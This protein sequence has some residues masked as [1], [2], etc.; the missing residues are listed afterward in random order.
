MPDT[1]PNPP[2]RKMLLIDDDPKLLLGLKA[3]MT[4]QGFEVFSTIDGN[5]GI[6]MAREQ[7]PDIIICDVMMPKPDGFSIKR[8]LAGNPQTA[9][10]P[11]IYL[12]ARTFTADKIAGLQLGADDYV[13]KPFNA[14]ELVSRVEAI[15][16]RGNIGHQRGLREMED[17]LEQMR[18]SISTN[19]AHE[20]RT[21]L[22][23]IMAN[24]TMAMKEKFHGRADDMNWY[25]E[26]MLSSTQKLFKLT[27]DMILLNDIDQGKLSSKRI[28]INL[29]DGLLKPIRDVTTRY[30]V[31]NLDVQVAVQE[32]MLLYASE[33]DFSRAVFH[34]VDNACKFSPDGARIIIQL[35][36]NGFGGCML[37]VENSGSSISVEL[38]EK[39]F[40]RYYQIQQGDDRPFEGLGIG[41]TIVRAVAEVC[42][43]S[44]TIKDSDMGCRVLFTLPPMFEK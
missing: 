42:G 15:L 21:P 5:E 24:L 44:A 27:E 13:S 26:S 22:T 35:R 20:L 28:P 19:L 17:R 31:K 41:L 40:E 43:G 3:V 12:T 6:R 18:N 16:R 38:R 36:R 23:V 39:V 32:D 25:L 8:F 7:L 30:Q 29:N 11:F 33:N 37:S 1:S 10:I 4:I 14:D 2:I 34:L 9:T